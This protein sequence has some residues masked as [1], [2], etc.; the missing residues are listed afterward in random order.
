M[1][2]TGFWGPL[3]YRYSK[4]IGQVNIEAPLLIQ[5]VFVLALWSFSILKYDSEE[6]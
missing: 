3:Y 2:Q 1:I 4:E 5:V 6:H